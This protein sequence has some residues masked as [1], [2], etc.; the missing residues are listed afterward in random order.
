MI[1][2][3]RLWTL[4]Y[5]YSVSSLHYA[6]AR[7]SIGHVKRAFFGKFCSYVHGGSVDRASAF[8]LR[9]VDSNLELVTFFLVFF[10]LIIA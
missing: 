6:H 2:W 3:L 10:F 1:L 7:D 8:D 9:A 4:A 5:A